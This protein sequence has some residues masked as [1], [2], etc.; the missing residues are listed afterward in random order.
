[1]LESNFSSYIFLVDGPICFAQGENHH[2]IL[3]F[4]STAEMAKDENCLYIM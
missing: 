2:L 1:M 3:S 4:I